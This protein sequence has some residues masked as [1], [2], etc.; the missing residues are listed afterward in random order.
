M[1]T[2]ILR[3]ETGGL[4]VV[5]LREEHTSGRHYRVEYGPD[6]SYAL[7]YT[8]AAEALG[9]SVMAELAA[10]GKLEPNV[11]LHKPALPG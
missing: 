3:V 10:L 11:E 9:L 8:Q 1:A 6:F 7:G 2:E 5:L 4:P